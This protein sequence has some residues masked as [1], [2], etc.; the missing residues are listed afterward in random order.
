MLR[1]AG[2][3]LAAVLFLSS[4]GLKTLILSH[5]DSS[6][7][8]GFVCLLF[9]SSYIAGVRKSAFSREHYPSFYQS[10][11]YGISHIGSF[12]DSRRH[13]TLNSEGPFQRSRTHGKC[14]RIRSRLLPVDCEY[15][16]DLGDVGFIHDGRERKKRDRSY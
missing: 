9:G 14:R 2:I 13:N 6:F 10:L 16:R 12:P 7:L 8:L 11:A 15:V 4:L 1:I 5:G 3:V